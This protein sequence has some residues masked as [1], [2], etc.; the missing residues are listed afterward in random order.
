M[1]ILETIIKH[2]REE[3][4]F[5]KNYCCRIFFKRAPC[6]KEQPFLLKKSLDN[7][8]YGIIAE[9]KR[10]SPSKPNINQKLSIFDVAKGL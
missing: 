5:R 7:S 4:A 2:K 10:R 3:I 8:E 1:S 9:H 6:L